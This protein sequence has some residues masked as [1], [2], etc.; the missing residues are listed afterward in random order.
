[1]TIDEVFLRRLESLARIEL[2]KEE[3]VS[4]REDL[5]RMVNSF[6]RLK[7]IDTAGSR[8]MVSPVMKKDVFYDD[9]ECES[10][11]YR[12]IQDLAPD[13]KEGRIVVSEKDRERQS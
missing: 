8:P 2:T 6:Q 13:I 4:I 11:D 9:T 1:M 10:S 12:E 3:R 5:E 7:D